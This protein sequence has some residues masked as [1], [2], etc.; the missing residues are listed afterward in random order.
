MILIIILYNSET[1]AILKEKED[2]K[3]IYI[4]DYPIPVITMWLIITIN[5][6]Q[7]YYQFSEAPILLFETEDTEN[8]SIADYSEPVMNK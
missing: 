7:V 4:T 8:V 6:N 1:P 5:F 2:F 3:N